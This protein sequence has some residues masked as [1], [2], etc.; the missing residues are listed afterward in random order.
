MESIVMVKISVILPVYNAEEYLEECLE[1]IA[2][3]SF[4]D[5]EII[6]VNDGSTDASLDVLEKRQK[7]DSRI[8]IITLENKGAGAARNVGL[9]HASGDYIYFMDSDDYLEL[10]AFEELFEL[11]NN[12][13]VD[14]VLF[15]IN[16]FYEDTKQTL[17]DDYYNMPYL[18]SEVKEETFNYE[19]IPEIA[20]DLCVCPPG[21]LFSHEFIKDLRFP[22]GLLF[23]DNVFFTHAIFKADRIYFHDKFLYNRRKRSNST[24]TPITVRSIDTIDITNMLLDLCE[25]YDHPRHK[26]ELYYRIFHNIYMIFKKADSSQKEQ[27]FQKIKHDYV[28]SEDKWRGDEYFRNELNPKYK[29]IFNCALKSKNAE[30]FEK[31]VDN[32]SKESRLKRLRNKLL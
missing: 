23:E 13:N 5:I 20:L 25:E 29:H 2:N 17:D 28:K 18:K 19:D 16:N 3:Q 15:K 24:T 26:G 4:K 9:E 32:Y 10:T 8:S 14:F 6:C 11:A 31:C 22:E 27:L 1:S 30:K 21:C 12:K 7:H